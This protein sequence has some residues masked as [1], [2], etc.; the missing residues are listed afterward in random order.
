MVSTISNS[1]STMKIVEAAGNSNRRHVLYAEKGAYDMVHRDF[2]RQLD[3]FGLTTAQIL[4]RLPDHPLLLQ[5]FVWQDY[6][7]CPTFPVLN[8]FGILVPHT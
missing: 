1:H 6:D 2:R 4:Y 5:T 3:G 8:V 7:Q